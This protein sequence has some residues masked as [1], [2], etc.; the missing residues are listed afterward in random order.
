MLEGGGGAKKA[1]I[2]I[3][4]FSEKEK[5]MQNFLKWKNMRKYFVTLLQG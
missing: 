5:K 1:V 3:G 4:F 2:E